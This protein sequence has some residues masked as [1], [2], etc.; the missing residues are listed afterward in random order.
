M[1][2][3]NI[4]E[5]RNK[6]N[7]THKN[8]E[9]IYHKTKKND[10]RN[11]YIKYQSKDDNEYKKIIITENMRKSQVKKN[12]LMINAENIIQKNEKHDKNFK[13]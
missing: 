8:S 2:V 9:N 12:V 5:W 1:S 13:N 10:W 7:T 6:I 4:I 3:K 11:H